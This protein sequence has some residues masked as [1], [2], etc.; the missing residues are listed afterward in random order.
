MEF[1]SRFWEVDFLRGLAVILMI[2]SNIA[3]DL[4]YFNSYSPAYPVFWQILAYAAASTFLFLVGVSLTLS[5]CRAKI[6]GRAKFRKYLKRG[7]KIFSLGLA[8][9]IM[10]YIFI[11]NDFIVFGVLHFIGIAVVLSYPFL[12][13]KHRYL[14]LFFGLVFIVLGVLAKGITMNSPWLLWLG[15][16]PQGFRSIDY[17]PVLPWF[18]V[19]LA[20]IFTG[21]LLY[22]DYKRRFSIP[23]ISNHTS[24]LF[25]FLGRHSLVIYLLHQPV[26]IAL[27]IFS[28]IISPAYLV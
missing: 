10:T 8:I 16:M 12:K 13:C 18:G 5:F 17:F 26:L 23:E 7:A 9:T 3:T 14:P 22:R 4:V 27:F 21:N 1:E 25:C 11:R 24:R 6:T 28:G 2:A 15:L 19:V 20:G